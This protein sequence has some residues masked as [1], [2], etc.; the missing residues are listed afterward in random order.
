ML[1]FVLVSMVT[2]AGIMFSFT[3]AA[4]PPSNVLVPMVVEKTRHGERAYDIFSCLMQDRI[5]FLRSEINNDMAD[6]IVAQLLFLNSQNP[7]EDIHIYIH[8]P[9]G[10]VDAGMAIYDAMH[11]VKADVCTYGIGSCSSMAAILLAAGAEG[12]RHSLPNTRIMIH[13]P[14]GSAQGQVS[15]LKIQAQEGEY[16]RDRL[17]EILAHHTGNDPEQIR[18]DIERDYYMSAEEAL[19]YGIVDEIINPD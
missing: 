5:I 14:L 6:I 19:E 1:R 8:S 3:S 12:K 17:T 15:D 18:A 13:Q 4:R 11:F 2:L 9:G 10:S 16:A 7:N